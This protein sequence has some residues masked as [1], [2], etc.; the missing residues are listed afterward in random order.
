[1]KSEPHIHFRVQLGREPGTRDLEFDLG[2]PEFAITEA[3]RP[4]DYPSPDASA[5]MQMIC[6]TPPIIEL[7]ELDRKRLADALGQLLTTKILQVLSSADRQMG[8]S[9]VAAEPARRVAIGVAL[10]NATLY[11]PGAR[12]GD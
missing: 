1:M 9:P 3:A 4:L 11:S 12:N 6:S 10:R 8:F 7:R 5:A 2:L